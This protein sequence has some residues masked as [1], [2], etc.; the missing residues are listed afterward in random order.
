MVGGI[1]SIVICSYQNGRVRI[2]AEEVG[3]LVNHFELIGSERRQSRL[4]E[5]LLTTQLVNALDHDLWVISMLTEYRVHE[6][7]DVELQ[8]PL[9][10]LLILV[11]VTQRLR[12]TCISCDP[13]N[14]C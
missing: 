1:T 5:S 3:S 13:H 2:D 7:P 14:T 12:I 9:A 11:S 4:C 6:P 10:R 8:G